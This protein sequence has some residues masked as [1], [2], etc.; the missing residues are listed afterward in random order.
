MLENLLL[1]MDSYLRGKLRV[2]LERMQNGI[3]NSHDT[4]RRNGD[5]IFLQKKYDQLREFLRVD[6]SS[7]NFT[8]EQYLDMI[9]ELDG[10]YHEFLDEMKGVSSMEEVLILRYW[11]TL[12]PRMHKHGLAMMPPDKSGHVLCK[13]FAYSMSYDACNIFSLCACEEYLALLEKKARLTEQEVWERIEAYARENNYFGLA[14][15]KEELV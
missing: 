8:I 6:F 10:L 14:Y 12:A 2:R 11:E 5:R 7:E 13:S 9:R 3:R 15:K 4:S 1:K